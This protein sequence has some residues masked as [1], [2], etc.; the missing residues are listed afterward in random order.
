MSG[1]G[2]NEPVTIHNEWACYNECALFQSFETTGWSPSLDAYALVNVNWA[3]WI[4]W[5]MLDTVGR[6][7]FL[8]VS[9]PCRIPRRLCRIRMRESRI[10]T[11][12]SRVK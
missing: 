12:T 11:G 7:G 2:H 9:G 8:C 3:Y 10:K 1:A 5:A 6:V 4:Q